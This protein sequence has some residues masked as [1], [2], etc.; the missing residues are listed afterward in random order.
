MVIGKF[1]GI[2]DDPIRL[3]QAIAYLES[4]IEAA[5]SDNSTEAVVPSGGSYGSHVE[6]CL[7]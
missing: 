4:A 2:G 1:D 5:G 7:S 6:L 3:A